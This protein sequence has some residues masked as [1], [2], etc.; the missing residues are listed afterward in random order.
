MQTLADAHDVV[1]PA[2]FID[3]LGEAYL[4]NGEYEAARA[5]LLRV[6]APDAQ[7]VTTEA[8]AV[9]SCLLTLAEVYRRVDDTAAAEETLDRCLALSDEGG[10]AEIRASA[11][12]ARAHLYAGQG[13]Y[14]EAFEQHLVFHREW[15]ELHQAE[16]DARARI[17]QAVFEAAEARQDSDRFRELSFRDPLTGLYNR[18]R[19]EERL[20]ALLAEAAETGGVVAVAIVD[21]DHFKQINDQC[22]HETGDLVLKAVAGYL[23]SAPAEGGFAARL[24]GEEFVL[25]LPGDDSAQAVRR[26]EKVRR[27]VHAHDWAPLTG[28]LPVT[29]SFG[30]AV[31]SAD[32]GSPAD[33]L[34]AADQNLYAAK[35]AGRDRVVAAPF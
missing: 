35:R 8:D 26:C 19:V 2:S 11:L 15:A 33:L 18:R 34:R 31:S 14:R 25:V 23:G 20:P 21:L 1:L 9:A 7:V 28:Q 13:R 29:A 27:L 6:A 5:A 10:L 17:T 24:G 4:A 12:L 22:S 16:S 3:T 30:V 32:T